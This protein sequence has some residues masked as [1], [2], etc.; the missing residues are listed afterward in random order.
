MAHGSLPAKG[1]ADRQSKHSP[2]L[3]WGLSPLI[4]ILANG[5][6]VP[7]VSDHAK[8]NVGPSKIS[9]SL[10]PYSSSFTN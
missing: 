1:K 2:V 6:V 3:N 8:P 4:P 7:L 9:E 5:I 10:L